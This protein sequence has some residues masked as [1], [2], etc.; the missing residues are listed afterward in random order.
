MKKPKNGR[1]FAHKKEHETA[2]QRV[3]RFYDA[4]GGPLLAWLIDEARQRGITMNDMSAELGVT[5]GYISQLRTG[6]RQLSCIGQEFAEA[7]ARFLGVPPIVVKLLAGR[8]RI[9]DFAWPDEGEGMLVERA[10]RQLKGDRTA[11]QH[12]PGDDSSLSFEAKR[13]LVMLYAETSGIDVLGLRKL[14]WVVEYLQRPVMNHN[15]NEVES[16]MRRGELSYSPET[17]S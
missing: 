2:P 15:D 17:V 12:L 10:F 16:F 3:Q 5:Y 1:V 14:N 6:I 7:S 4:D 8:I 13:A 9:S 11:S